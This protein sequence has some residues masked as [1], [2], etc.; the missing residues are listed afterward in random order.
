ME[1]VEGRELFDYVIEKHKLKESEACFIIK[2]LLK[3]IKYIHSIGIIHRDLKPENIII[4][5]N[6]CQIKLI[7]F[8]LSTFY[9]EF[10]SLKTKVGTPY[11][12]APELLEG[13]YGPEIDIWSIGVIAYI[14]LT[15]YPPF[16]GKSNNRIYARIRES[17]VKFRRSEWC[18]L[19]SDSMHL[20]K[21]ILT[22]DIKKRISVT[23][24]LEHN[25]IKNSQE[26]YTCDITPDIA[27]KLACFKLPD[28]L[29]KEVFLIVANQINS[30]IVKKWT[31]TFEELDT[32]GTG[33]IKIDSL[34]NKCKEAGANTDYLEKLKAMDKEEGDLKINY[35]DFLAK[36]ININKEV[37]DFDIEKAFKHLDST[38][39]G[40]ITKENLALFLK[41]KG[42]EDAET[43]AELL[44]TSAHEKLKSSIIDTDKK[45]GK[46]Y[47]INEF[48]N[49]NYKK[50][51]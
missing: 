11:Y 14:L 9:Q 36:V 19:S 8:G 39:T 46:L 23:Q 2:Q 35:S 43:N 40:K 25:W 51:T 15:G 37:S 5:S 4:D 41:R 13:S 26:K 1:F 7:D 21:Q 24:A 34:I 31:Y 42:D 38:G 45:Y 12:V 48:F 6:T 20:V 49:R 16:H 3:T 22:K 27:K 32:E 33:M 18:M 10:V 50:K 47:S 28:M 30:D 17:E 44:L 29:K